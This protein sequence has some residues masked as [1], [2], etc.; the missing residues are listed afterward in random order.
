MSLINAG[1]ILVAGLNLGMALLIW[2]RNPKNKINIYFA[3]AVLM[4][5]LW[6]FGESMTRMA[7]TEVL[8]VFWGRFENIFGFLSSFFFLF[9]AVHY[10]Y[11]LF[12]LTKIHK[13]IILLIAA[14][15]IIITM[16]PLYIYGAI[17]QPPATDFLSY[18]FGNQYYAITFIGFV[19]YSYYLLIRKYRS[20]QGIIKR[21]L[22]N[23]IVATGII[24]SFG[25]FFGVVVTMFTAKNNEWFVPY[26]SIPMVVI[27]V[28]FIF[29][30][31]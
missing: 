11:E 29:K 18:N 9:F 21:N 28:W 20:S 4:I 7:N 17:V 3:L 19:L 13:F 24:A 15:T 26:F 6:S 30:K 23:I 25:V 1:L 8:G 10:P 31:E 27:L 2:M 12:K 16:T 22:M 5:G 14:S